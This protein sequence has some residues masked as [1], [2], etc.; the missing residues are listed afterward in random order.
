MKPYKHHL[1]AADYVPWWLIIICM[2]IVITFWTGV[3]LVGYWLSTK[4]IL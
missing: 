4:I 2:L 1:E 3:I